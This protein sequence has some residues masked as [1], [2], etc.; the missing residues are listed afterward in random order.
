MNISRPVP[1][2]RAQRGIGV[3]ELMV[4]MV[5]GL[6]LLGGTLTLFS[7]NK[8]TY[9]VND[10]LSRLQENARFAMEFLARDIR[11]AGY[12][13]CADNLANV[14]VHV[15]FDPADPTDPASL[16]DTS[17][18]VEGYEEN[19]ASWTPSGSTAVVGGITPNTDGISVR[20]I[21]PGGAV[22]Q[23][24]YMPTPSAALH[25][26]AGNGL[27]VGDII[28]VNDCDSTDVFQIT[29]P[30][31]PDTSG[32]INHNTGT[33]SPG[34]ATKNLSKTYEGDAQIV[35][36]VGRRYTIRDTDYDG[37]GTVDGPS[38]YRT[39]YNPVGG[40]AVISTD[41]LVRGV[42]NM[43]ILFGEDTT[44]DRQ[45]DVY[46][47]TDDVTSWANVVSVRVGLLLR[48]VDEYDTVVDNANV[49]VFSG[50]RGCADTAANPGCVPVAGLRVQRRAFTSTFLMRNLQ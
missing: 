42:E 46:V 37:D 48:T 15:N 1:S 8:K 30:S 11:M 26:P 23:P 40:N 14:F 4:A 47:D 49:D 35:R 10:D 24:P 32:T 21:A 33:G 2:R 50:A 29:G 7:T 12:F 34:N 13:G 38:L 22:V 31:V 19:G 43:Q 20:Y 25:L 28:A 41:E 44:G 16:Y 3:I 36:F 5:L 45:P 18:P 9:E 17:N 39:A 6:F 27:Q